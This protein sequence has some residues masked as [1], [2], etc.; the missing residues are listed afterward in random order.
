M[1]FLVSKM[2][3]LVSGMTQRIGKERKG[4]YSILYI[5]IIMMAKLLIALSGVGRDSP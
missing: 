1:P 2:P 3:F 5:M 4:N